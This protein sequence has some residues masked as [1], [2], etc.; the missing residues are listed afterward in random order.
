[1]LEHSLHGRDEFA[2]PRA[3]RD[4]VLLAIL[5]LGFATLLRIA[6][7]PDGL[8]RWQDV[9][10][11]TAV[12]EPATI[13]LAWWLCEVPRY[14]WAALLLLIVGV[15]ASS[16]QPLAYP[17]GDWRLPLSM[18]ALGMR[19][20]SQRRCRAWR[21]GLAWSNHQNRSSQSV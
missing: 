14:R 4:R 15:I 9:S 5:S 7:F 12:L 17:L 20:C 21:R 2:A 16:F 3:G 1:M 11:G 19:H 10:S 18:L 6:V 13:C 8:G